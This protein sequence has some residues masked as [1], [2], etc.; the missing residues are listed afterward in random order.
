VPRDWDAATYDRIADPMI[1]WGATV[2]DRLELEGGET[3]LDA[4][5]G[6]GRVTELLLA[7]LPRGHVIALDG[8]SSMIEHARYR[9]APAGDRISLVVADLID[10][11]P[12][13]A[14]DA[15]VSTATFHWIRDHDRLFAN[16]AAVLPPDGR[17]EAQCGGAGNLAS[18][19]AALRAMG[20]DPFG[21]K[22]YA[23]P[24]ETADRL[25][26]AGFV[27]IECWLHP[28]PTPFGSLPEL[29]AYLRTVALGDHV[30]GMS[31]PEVDG[32]ALQV[33]ERMPA[34]E[35]DYVRL[36]IR[37]VRA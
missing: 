17:L 10:P 14:V 31:P 33:V 37:A 36:N 22:R 7:R 5:C 3:V 12:V 32:F 8:S 13:R 1:R 26:R 24:E 25:R 35:L 15:I 11:L 2:V 6:S 18:V 4:G 34:L 20:R 19:A 9:L 28:E 29:A 30:A 27:D 21:T 23:T 16:L